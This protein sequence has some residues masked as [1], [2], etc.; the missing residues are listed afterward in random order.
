MLSPSDIFKAVKSKIW[1]ILAVVILVTVAMY[2]VTGRMA[3]KY[4]SK[5]QFSTGITE[6]SE[7][8]ISE[9]KEV[10]QP[11]AI[12]QRFTNLIEM[13]RSRQC[14]SMVQYKLLLHELTDSVPFRRPEHF[15]KISP[16]LKDSIIAKLHKRLDSCEVLNLN[17][18]LDK[19]IN[20]LIKLYNYDQE[21]ILGRTG[22]KRVPDSDFISVDVESENPEL[23]SELANIYVA[24]FIRFYDIQTSNRSAGSVNFFEKMARIKKRELDEKVDILKRFKL[25]NRVINLYEQ[26]K[27]IV[28]QLS[29]IEIM[30]EEENMKIPS[31][32]REIKDIDERFTSKEKRYY[33]A[34]SSK[35]NG[36]IETLKAEIIKLNDRYYSSNMK[37]KV[38]MDSILV[39][40]KDMEKLI[41][42]ASDENLV[43]PNAVK[44]ALVARKLN[45]EL[46]KE[47]AIQSVA[48][49]D[50]DIERLQGIITSFTPMEASIGAYEREISVASEVY[51]LVL[52]K[53]NVAQFAALH[54]NNSLKQAEF[55]Q[56]A[57]RPESSKKVMILALSVGV[58]LILSLM[59]VIG[60]AYMD[61]T[62]YNPTRFEAATGFH[63]LSYIPELKSAEL[64]FQQLFTS[65][66]LS[67]AE[68]FFARH[69]RKIRQELEAKIPHHQSILFTGTK[70]GEGKTTLL[71]SLAYAF[72]LS[73]KKLLL[74]DGNFR[75]A[76]LT[77]VLNAP[78][79]LSPETQEKDVERAI[80][81]TLIPHVDIIGC[82]TSSATPS[83][84]FGRLLPDEAF[85]KLKQQYDYIF[86]EGPSL[87]D[88][89][90]SRELSDLVDH[91]VTVFAAHHALSELDREALNFIVGLKEKHIGSILNIVP[92][93]EIPELKSAKKKSKSKGKKDKNK[94]GP[95][96]KI[97]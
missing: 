22:I 9:S 8:S 92:S 83:E 35:I 89:S 94:T 88:W 31:M 43:N 44:T 91:V 15:P 10:S 32:D 69:V 50:K 14:V 39:L 41:Q 85:E 66:Q 5:A 40:R 68:L 21:D 26:T 74:V 18:K 11:F 56:P 29:S 37:D 77:Q 71:L 34:I 51:L 28:N 62:F 2:F 72:S 76:G 59:V 7:I 27:S 63:L 70:S 64:Q 75:N 49:I 58:S 52:N 73:G 42:Q 78:A 84:I 25:K 81:P 16:T 30:R 65:D 46:D 57:E 55:A 61:E 90:D 96:L 1:W 80:A 45:A 93:K 47:M 82:A 67:P 12:A 38:A 24:E 17:D 95:A 54:D 53:L 3:K 48:S 36:Q 33:E 6:S 97:A 87:Q 13:M 23:S 79:Y 19:D 4:H 60:M 86:I 20:N